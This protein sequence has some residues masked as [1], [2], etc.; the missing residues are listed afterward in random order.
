MPA[1]LG[2]SSPASIL[3]DS[4]A[5]WSGYPDRPGRLGG[6]KP[7]IDDRPKKRTS[8]RKGRGRSPCLETTSMRAA[9]RSSR[10]P[11]SNEV[12]ELHPQAPQPS[13]R[14]FAPLSVFN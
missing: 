3:G 4:G 6:L 9:D 14:P 13:M 10:L 12:L 1:T 5:R 8:Y 7:D 11:G 2:G